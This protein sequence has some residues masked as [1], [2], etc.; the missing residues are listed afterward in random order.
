M[1]LV[2]RVLVL[3]LYAPSAHN[4]QAWRF[5]V[6]SDRDALLYVDPARLLLETDPPARQIHVSCGCFAE[7]FSLGVS[8][9]R[10]RAQVDL[11]P[12]GPYLSLKDI[13]QLPVARLS[14]YGVGPEDLLAAYIES[15]QTS[16]LP[17]EGELITFQP[18]FPTVNTI[19]PK[20]TWT[21]WGESGALRGEVMVGA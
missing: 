8:R 13:G 6:F 17:Y 20:L 19:R 21:A 4:T 2:A 3:A 1:P 7:A 18:F 15:R 12:E 16:R 5:R 10:L 14:P 9:Y 11:F